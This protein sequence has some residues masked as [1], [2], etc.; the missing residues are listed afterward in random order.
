MNPSPEVAAFLEDARAAL[1]GLQ[2]QNVTVRTF[3]N[4]AAI[5]EQ[6]I[7]LIA[8]GA[9]TGTF[10]LLAEY[11]SSG[12][13]VPHAGDWV[14]VTQFDGRPALL[15]RLDE[16]E[17]LP[18]LAIAE[19]HVA[20]EGPRLRE[21]GAWRRVHIEYWTPVLTRLGRDFSDDLPIVFQRFT[22]R[23]LAVPEKK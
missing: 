22:V 12:L 11:E 23:F 1:P 6:L 15:Y 19:R 18:F 20:L 4:D 2:I 21:L 17:V 9:K 16:V 7:A 3:G 5:A 10:A 13:P 8:S 14:A